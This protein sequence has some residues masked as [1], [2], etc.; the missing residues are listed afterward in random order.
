MSSP[1]RSTAAGILVVL[2]LS[3]WSPASVSAQCSHF[4]NATDG[5]DANPGTLTQP[6]RSVENAFDRFPSGSVV[7]VSAGEYYRGADADGVSLASPGKSMRFVLNAF[8]GY[9]EV[10][11]SEGAF[12]VDVGTG[13]VRFEAGTA[14]RLVFGPGVDNRHA[15]NGAGLNFLHSMRLNSGTIEFAVPE[16]VVSSSVGNPDFV[17]PDEPAKRAPSDAA[18]EYGSVTVSGSVSFEPSPRRV[19]FT[20]TGP[21]PGFPMPAGPLTGRLQFEQ[22]GPVEFSGLL[23][24]DGVTVRVTGPGDVL[25]SGGLSVS[26]AALPDTLLSHRGTGRV[27]IASLAVAGASTGSPVLR[28]HPGSRLSVGRLNLPAPGPSARFVVDAGAQLDLGEDGFDGRLAGSLRNLGRVRLEGNLRLEAAAGVDAALDNRGTIELDDHDLQLAAGARGHV[29]EGSITAVTGRLV[30]LA[31]ISMTGSGSLPSIRVEAGTLTTTAGAVSGGVHVNGGGLVFDAPGTVRIADALEMDSGTLAVRS[32]SL[33]VAGAV[34]I[35]GGALDLGSSQWILRSDVRLAP[36]D[37]AF[38]AGSAL[39]MASL[40]RATASYGPRPVPEV[41][42]GGAG[43]DLSGSLAVSGALLVQEGGLSIAAGGA[44]SAEHIRI[45]APLELGA[46]ASLAAVE[47]IVTGPSGRLTIGPSARIETG[48]LVLESGSRVEGA[49]GCEVSAAGGVDAAPG[50]AWDAAACSIRIPPGSSAAV[51]AATPLVVS[52]LVFGAGSDVDV[53]G[54]VVLTDLLD[55]ADA[56]LRL[57]AGASLAGTSARVGAGSGLR[58]GAGSTLD[59][60]GDLEATGADVH[61][62]PAQNLRVGGNLVLDS[63]TF[64]GTG[65][66]NWRL[67]GDLDVIGA[68]TAILPAPSVRW[69]GA[70][71]SGV[72]AS[73]PIGL[74]SLA[75][76]GPR[77]TLDAEVEVIGDLVVGSG[78]VTVASGRTA[79]IG[80]SATAESAPVLIGAGST[81]EVGGSTSVAGGSLSIADGGTFGFGGNVDL[82]SAPVSANGGTI[83]ATGSGHRT[84]VSSQA[85]A[86][87][88]FRVL[89]GVDL[90]VRIPNGLDVGGRLDIPAG[91]V[92][93]S[94]ATAVRLSGRLPGAALHVDGDLDSSELGPA[95]IGGPSGSGEIP[96]PSGTGRVG[97]IEI[98]LADASSIVTADP[99]L[100]WVLGGSLRLVSGSLDLGGGELEFAPDSPPA[101][102]FVLGPE[103]TA[104]AFGPAGRLRGSSVNAA[105][106]PF[107]LAFEGDLQ[108]FYTLGEER[109]LGPIRNLDVGA[110]DRLNSPPVFAV[111]AAGPLSI[112]GALRVAPG[113]LLR[114]P[115]DTLTLA[116]PGVIHRLDGT[117]EGNGVLRVGAGSTVDAAGTGSAR[118]VAIDAPPSEPVTLSGFTSLG[119]LDVVG[120][121]VLVTGEGPLPIGEEMRFRA[122]DSSL[123]RPVVLG[124][125]S[126]VAEF[127]LGTGARLALTGAS[128]IRTR[129]EAEVSVADGASLE[130]AGEPGSGFLELG[131]RTGLRALSPIPR[132]RLAPEAGNGDDIFFLGDVRIGER[133]EVRDADLFLGS[134]DLVLDGAD[135][136]HDTDGQAGD[137]VADEIVGDFTGAGGRVIFAGASTLELGSDLSL[138]YSGLLVDAGTSNRVTVLPTDHPRRIVVANRGV[139][140]RSGVLD[141]GRHSL[142]LDGASDP[143]L[144]LT[145]GVLDATP[146]TLAGSRPEERAVEML[147]NLREGAVVVRSGRNPSIFARGA[148][149]IPNLVLE[150]SARMA[151]SSA[152]LRVTRRLVFGEADASLVTASPQ[153]LRLG[154]GALLVRRGRGAL[155]NPPLAEGAV[156]VAYDL[157]DGDL[158]G[159]PSGFSSTTLS[160]GAELPASNP[161][162]DLILLPGSRSGMANRLLLSNPA[163]VR[164]D[165]VFLGGQLDLGAVDLQLEPGSRLV[166]AGMDPTAV[167]ELRRTTGTIRTVSSADVH[168]VS[169]HRDVQLTA[170]LVPPTLAVD[171]LLVRMGSTAPPTRQAVLPV[172]RTVGHLL[173]DSP[174]PGSGLNLAGRTLTVSGSAHLRSGLLHSTPVSQL[175]VGGSLLVGREATVEGSISASVSGPVRVEG[176][177]AGSALAAGGDV[178]LTGDLAAGL[179]L[180]FTGAEQALLLDGGNETVAGLVLNQAGTR[181][182][183][184]L[185]RTDGTPAV[186]SYSGSLRLERG[187]LRTGIHAVRS[188]TSGSAIARPG[189]AASHVEGHF[190]QVLPAGF[191]GTVLFPVGGRDTYRPMRLS[192]PTGLLSSATVTV[193]GTDDDPLGQLGLP[194][195]LPDGAVVRGIQPYQWRL[196]SSVNFANSQIYTISVDVDEPS[197]PSALRLVT[198]D[199]DSPFLTWRPIRGTQA[200]S[201]SGPA[202]VDIASTGSSGGLTPAGLFVAVGAERPRPVQAGLQLLNASPDGTTVDWWI[203]GRPALSSRGALTGSPAVDVGAFA[204]GT[205]VSV[206]ARVAGTP[207][208]S[209]ALATGSVSLEDGRSSVVALLGSGGTYALAAA[210]SF[211]TSAPPSDRVDVAFVHDGSL[212]ADLDIMPWTGSESPLFVRVPASEWTVA[213]SV[214]IPLEGLGFV[215]NG[216]RT[217]FRLADAVAGGS[218]LAIVMSR[219][220]GAEPS[221]QAFRADGSTVGSV[222]RTDAEPSPAELPA[223][224]ALHGNYPNPF[225]PVTTVVFDL[226][227]AADVRLQVFDALGRLV[228]TV[229]AGLV[230]AGAGRSVRFEAGDLATG[231]YFYRLSAT[232]GRARHVATGRF[233]LVR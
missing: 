141:L 96:V 122:G 53:S 93:R 201:T 137:G 220:T 16:V 230:D 38:G 3:A 27:L 11:F 119:G 78:A 24:V 81:L 10:R 15:V 157:D 87:A 150:R 229:E 224:F 42:V 25:L 29:N 61:V 146:A 178:A 28:A 202:R 47:R 198:R 226:P 40:A 99:G 210:P 14:S 112:D 4:V 215:A 105:R 101:L 76:D 106:R 86:T 194:M 187:V 130:V 183:V 68:G 197:D 221:M 169:P 127:E 8:A 195:S 114:V 192:F 85:V 144:S 17:N 149:D 156:D 30:G 5:A 207:G 77:L 125:E 184:R 100:R 139:E 182:S 9:G 168:V 132:L 49:A 80:G 52:S 124:S 94:P 148:S 225:N 43:Y 193:R 72:R 23:E 126:V 115:S 129:G 110:I 164:G 89:S 51:A 91:A 111:D 133:L 90:T 160:T 145:G 165:V 74:A 92:L 117:V 228:R 172:S 159:Q 213:T 60:A 113:G 166:L 6:V 88:H 217:R 104:P 142:L 191:S 36:Q 71:A 73:V 163:A 227:E 171:T 186:L 31:T 83:E 1:I 32:A 223:V 26:G 116:G 218:R 232:A 70:G 123:E 143:V 189:A 167:P 154:D 62:E 2:L 21:A 233:V 196:S 222:V 188:T 152:A 69:V 179:T 219:G 175:S 67:G 103:G 214:P 39:G 19:R 63:A 118:R 13:T 211:P 55:L 206:E 34:R 147:R 33:E 177:F 97:H 59:L 204:E 216:E 173:L 200:A 174:A 231:A 84:F 155:A 95:V 205:A 138:V 98:E 109:D 66:W 136:L 185:E 153:Q 203:G 176:T 170:D 79:R 162:R 45:D 212:G 7:C 128:G 12:R 135:W 181:P 46:S 48:M 209:P 102:S 158:T 82:S 57:A 180:T 120:G 107:D 44:A 64:A 121:G 208:T 108:A 58:L 190:Q 134:S 140:I 56:N 35:V 75:I 37:L 18:I 151:D 22:G 131:G 65:P 161:V 41:V 54:T 50:I 20:G 199:G